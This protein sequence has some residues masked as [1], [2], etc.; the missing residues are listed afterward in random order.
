MSGNANG[1]PENCAPVRIAPWRAT[2]IQTRS[3][4]A[5]KGSDRLAAWAIIKENIDHALG[6]IDA[7]TQS[8]EPPALVVLPEFALQG[9]PHGLPAADWIE[10]ASGPLPGAITEPL[11]GLARRRQIYIG[12]HQFESDPEWPGRY[13]NQYQLPDRPRRRRDPALSADQYRGFSFAA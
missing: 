12:A 11:Q 13:F 3:R 6:L 7:T 5:V 4:L 2:C 1:S 8:A 10:K 9:P